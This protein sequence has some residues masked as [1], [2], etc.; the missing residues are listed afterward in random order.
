MS[1]FKSSEN[2]QKKEG[3]LDRSV[4]ENQ[5]SS[6]TLNEL[7]MKARKSYCNFKIWQRSHTITDINPNEVQILFFLFLFNVPVN[8]FSVMLRQSHLFLGITSTFG[9]FK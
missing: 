6:V 3:G 5:S 1:S 8:N 7:A 9:E 4:L 2:S